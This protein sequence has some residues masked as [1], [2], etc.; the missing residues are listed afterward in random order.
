MIAR[1]YLFSPG[2]SLQGGTLKYC[3]ASSLHRDSDYH[4]ANEERIMEFAF[5]EQQEMLRTMARDFGQN[6]CPKS[7]VRAMDKDEKGFP[8]ALWKKMAELGWIELIIPEKYGGMSSS[9]MDFLVLMEEVGRACIP[10]PFFTNVILGGMT[11]LLEAAKH[12]SRL[13]CRHWL[14]A[15][16]SSLLR[17][18]NRA[19]AM[20]L[21]LFLLWLL[22]KMV[23]ISLTALNCLCLTLILPIKWFALRERLKG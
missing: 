20:N 7:L 11:V 13:C 1:S 2:Y 22:L 14:K 23:V 18:L 16:Q 9:F 15:K 5:N 19:P 8:E 6:E 12:K 4:G 21:P 17:S 3:E 10:G